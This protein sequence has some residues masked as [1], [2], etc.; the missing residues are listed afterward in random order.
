MVKLR[1]GRRR[2]VKT[3]RGAVIEI[4]CEHPRRLQLDGDPA[5]GT[6]RVFGLSIRPGVLPVLVPLKSPAVV[7]DEQ[8]GVRVGRV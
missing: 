8:V 6:A 1:L 5:G 3:R 2:G 7:S 4:R